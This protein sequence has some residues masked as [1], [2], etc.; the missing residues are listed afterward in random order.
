MRRLAAAI[1]KRNLGV[2]V[3]SILTDCGEAAII[4]C[5]FRKRP[6]VAFC[7]SCGLVG[8]QKNPTGCVDEEAQI[9]SLSRVLVTKVFSLRGT[10]T[11]NQSYDTAPPSSLPVAIEGRCALVCGRLD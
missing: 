1:V 9:E 7:N 8:L 5:C 2:L 3:D 6:D 11:F 4:P 10:L